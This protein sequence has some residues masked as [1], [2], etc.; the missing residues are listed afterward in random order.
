MVV[1]TNDVRAQRIFTGMTTRAVTTVVANGNCFGECNIEPECSSNSGCYLSNFKRVGEASALVVVGKHKH[2]GFAGE[3]AKSIGVQDAVA[4]AFETG[5]KEVGRLGNGSHACPKRQRGKWAKELSF[6][7]F[8]LFTC[9]HALRPCACRGSGVGKANRGRAVGQYVPSHGGC[10]G[11]SAVGG[12]ALRV[13]CHE[14]N[15]TT[16][17]SHN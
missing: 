8:S 4:V 13:M 17:V 3:A 6:I 12:G 14:M 15:D 5:A 7:F 16:W 9:D 2:L 1:A 10:P 11:T